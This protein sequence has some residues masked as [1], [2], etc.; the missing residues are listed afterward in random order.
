MGSFTGNML[1]GNVPKIIHLVAIYMF[2]VLTLLSCRLLSKIWKIET[3]KTIF[4]PV[5]I[6]VLK[7]DHLQLREGLGL[8]AC[9]KRILR[10]II[11]PK[12]NESWDRRRL[13]NEEFQSLYHSPNIVRIYSRN[14]Q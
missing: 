7:H 12:R 5:L 11:R 10:Q 1:R 13:H 6:M 3:Y 2:N 9:E 4:L 14:P 8:M